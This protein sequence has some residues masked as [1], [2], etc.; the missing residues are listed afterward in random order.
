MPFLRFCVYS[1]SM[2]IRKKCQQY[3]LLQMSIFVPSNTSIK[4]DRHNIAHFNNVSSIKTKFAQ[5]TPKVSD[6]AAI[7][8]HN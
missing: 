8:R 2:L 1:T 5:V 3:N 6:N 4:F 7:M